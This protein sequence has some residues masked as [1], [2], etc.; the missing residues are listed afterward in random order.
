MAL[1]LA[2]LWENRSTSPIWHISERYKMSRGTL[3]S[4]LTSASSMANSLGHALSGEFLTDSELWAFAHL[5]PEFATRLS[6]CVTSELIPLM[7]LPGVK[8]VSFF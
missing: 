6:Y 7:E 8:R 5:L 4:L 3:Q 1:V 2:E